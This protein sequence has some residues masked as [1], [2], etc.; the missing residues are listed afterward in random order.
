MNDHREVP[1]LLGS[2]LR[3]LRLQ[4]GLTLRD[5]ADKTGLSTG[6][7]SKV[8]RGFSQ[9]SINNLHKICYVLHIAI[10]DLAAPRR[11]SQP[12]EHPH[13]PAPGSPLIKKGQRSLIYN[14]N[15]MVKLESIFS[16]SSSYKLD[17]LTL[18][19]GKVEYASKHRYEEVGIVSQGRMEIQFET[20]QTYLMDEGDV[21]QIPADT[22]HT[23]RNLSES[24]CV[25][26]WFKLMDQA[27]DGEV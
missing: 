8:E 6:F 27:D 18:T 7:L 26:F 23:V 19:G 24:P 4:H 20:G 15:H 11:D 22:E 3:D 9:P 2:T 14:V 13:P 12:P 17:V 21:L 10:D 1:E 5:M 25:S 16:A